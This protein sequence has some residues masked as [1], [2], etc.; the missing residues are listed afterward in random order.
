MRIIAGKARGIRLTA[1]PGKDIRPT[2]D[3]VRESLF[4]ILGPRMAE[5]RFLDLFSG[6]GAIGLEA[7]SRG[8]TRVTFVDCDTQSLGTVRENLARTKLVGQVRCARLTLPKGLA[9][10]HGTF[11]IVFADP[12]YHYGDYDGLLTAI[13]QAPLLAPEALLVLKHQRGAKMPPAAGRL[14]LS[15]DKSYGDTVLSFYTAEAAPV[16]E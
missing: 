10:I 12:P 14:A 2:L 6:T 9:E 3:R 16:A 8:A 11:D 5:A 13:G 1:L 15:R 4:N 7:L